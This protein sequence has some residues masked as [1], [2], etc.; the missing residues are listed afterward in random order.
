M[1]FYYMMQYKTL[2]LKTRLKRDCN[3]TIDNYNNPNFV[4]VTVYPAT[5]NANQ[6]NKTL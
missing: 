1:V 3:K 2:L 5:F 6:E 4:I